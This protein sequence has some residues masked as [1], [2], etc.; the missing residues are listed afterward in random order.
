MTE[1]TRFE[2]F[3]PGG[4]HYHGPSD[5]NGCELP[6]VALVRLSDV[7]PERVAWLWPAYLPVGKL[8][9]LDGDPS[10]GKSTL[11][12]EFA[13]IVSTGSPWP[14]GDVCPAGDVLILSAED[15]LADTIR[16]RLDAAGADVARI[17]AIQGVPTTDED[18][19][20]TL[21][22][23][24][25]ADI[26]ALTGAIER[27]GAVLLIVDVLMAYVPAGV[28]SHRDQDIRAVLARLSAMAERTGCT[29]LL[30]R[31]LN[32]TPGRNPLYRGGGSI[33]IVGAARAG[34][35][36]AFDPDDESRRVLAVVK[37]NLAPMPPSL[38]YQLVAEG[39]YGAARVAWA[40]QTTHTAR[41]LLDEPDEPGAATEAERWL[42]DYIISEGGSVKSKDAKKAA[43][44]VRI[45]ERTLQ[46]AA[47]KLKLAVESHG[48][49][50]ETF[51]MWP[52][53]DANG[54]TPPRTHGA[55]GA[56]GATNSDQ[57]QQTG[58]VGAT[59]DSD[60]QSRQSRQDHVSGATE[61]AESI[62]DLAASALTGP[63]GDFE[64]RIIAESDEDSANDDGLPFS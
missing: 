3:T 63:P 10:V 30:L 58:P 25:L 37:S 4:R 53:S 59:G 62:R 52:A 2:D 11:S 44:K 57:R 23:P 40:G 6:G 39:S 41:S 33:G 29:V 13:A 64:A 8:V 18:G 16:P 28:D 20:R 19:E 27:T 32:K 14:D 51:W 5:T 31:H 12:D 15:G 9:T 34:L 38:G 36:A 7:E 60:S 47:K 54:T 21:R 50:R 46:R 35:L 45:A 55:I 26:A 49:P 22:P 61:A 17:H 48:F 42:E 56:T 43:A 24:T 1:A